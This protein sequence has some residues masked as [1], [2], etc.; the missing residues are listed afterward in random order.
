[1]S[2]DIARCIDCVLVTSVGDSPMLTWPTSVAPQL[3]SMCS[4]AADSVTLLV[5]VQGN[6]GSTLTCLLLYDAVVA[7]GVAL[8]QQDALPAVKLQV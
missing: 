5:F 2:F 1:M 6:D 8:S 3:E 4:A 7:T